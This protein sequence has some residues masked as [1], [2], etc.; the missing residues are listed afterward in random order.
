MCEMDVWK[1]VDFNT[2]MSEMPEP[3]VNTPM[4]EMDEP[5]A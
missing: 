1:R 5:D 4:S 3:G 2:S